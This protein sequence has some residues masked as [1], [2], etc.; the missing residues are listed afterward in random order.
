M[1]E[2]YEN[3]E[4]YYPNCE[5]QTKDWLVK[6]ARPEWVYFDCGANIGYY[7]ILFSQLS[8][9]GHVH[10]V[11]PTSTVNMLA[12]NIQ[13]NRCKNVTIHNVAV[14]NLTGRRIDKIFRIWGVAAEEIECNFTSVDEL[15]KEYNVP[16][17]DCI[18]IDVDSYDFEV[19]KGAEHAIQKY[20]PWIIIE[21]SNN[22]ALRN[23]SVKEV[24]EWLLN[25]G[26]QNAIILDNENY[27]FRRNDVANEADSIPIK[28][29]L[30]LQEKDILFDVLRE[31]HNQVT[32]KEVDWASNQFAVN[33][34]SNTKS[35]IDDFN[36]LHIDSKQFPDWQCY[37]YA[38]FAKAFNAD[39]IIQFGRWSGETL[40]SLI[41]GM[42]HSG[43][44]SSCKIWSYCKSDAEVWEN[45]DNERLKVFKHFP[46][47]EDLARILKEHDRVLVFWAD[48]T[49][50]AGDLILSTI[51]PMLAGR[52]HAVILH[53]VS[54]GRFKTIPEYSM[55]S[56]DMYVSGNLWS[57]RNDLPRI[58]DF[59]DRNRLQL[60]SPERAFK[61]IIESDIQLST[62]LKNTLGHL[63]SISAGWHWFTLNGH[64][65]PIMFPYEKEQVSNS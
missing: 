65:T 5:L 9:K 22:L 34:I 64:A 60:L 47:K 19:L 40:K 53:A 33:S 13:Y 3:F 46:G 58:V 21:L 2:Y 63:Y 14:G 23:S 10:A 11:E 20:N 59:I 55:N 36:A 7:T 54:D 28:L 37:Q 52:E 43:N 15:V 1:P 41:T 49:V 30:W 29:I 12:N 32:V 25:L 61:R 62:K 56:T 26:Y 6:H 57:S 31:L 27:L 50:I 38:A 8:P 24:L 44:S 45:V 18:K 48:D 4:W 17:L 35:M 39:C 16:R 51:L 42:E